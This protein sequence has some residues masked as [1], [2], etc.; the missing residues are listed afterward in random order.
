MPIGAQFAGQPQR[1]GGNPSQQ[2]LVILLMPNDQ[3]IFPDKLPS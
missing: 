1:D 2:T 3:E